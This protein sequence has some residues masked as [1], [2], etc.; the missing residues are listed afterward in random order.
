[1]P[2]KLD[3]EQS[4][5]GGGGGVSQNLVP[6][7]S[8]KFII[9]PAALSTTIATTTILN[10]PSGNANGSGTETGH[11]AN[12]NGSGNMSQPGTMGRSLKFHS[13]RS[14]RGAKASLFHFSN[15]P[16]V[17]NRKPYNLLQI[18]QMELQAQL[19]WIRLPCPIPP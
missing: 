9:V 10:N 14:V 7:N 17:L 6:T 18:N 16:T 3:K 11:P 5:G 8:R 4:V 15:V 12:T 2:N 1:M 19:L 13:L